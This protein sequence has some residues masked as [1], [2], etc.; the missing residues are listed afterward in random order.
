MPDLIST[1]TKL[2]YVIKLCCLL[3]LEPEQIVTI[4]LENPIDPHNHVDDK[5]I[6]LDLIITLN[7]QH[8]INI[9]MQV[10]NGNDWP[11]RSLTYLC[12]SF[13]N[14]KHGQIYL[15]KMLAST[16]KTFENV[17]NTMHRALADE[18]IR[19]KCEARE[20]YERDRISLYASGHRE[21]LKEGQLKERTSIIEKLFAKG[22]S[23]T[24]I[25]SLL[26]ITSDEVNH[27]TKK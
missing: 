9:E 13:D 5:E 1:I 15:D 19:L 11:E 20:R 22:M 7:N 4:V 6:V 8:K 24:D 12:R 21:G 2:F 10:I 3:N 25:A 27:V 17:A 18:E 26:D 16:D 14:L 23:D